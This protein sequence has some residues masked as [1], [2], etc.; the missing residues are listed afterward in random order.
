MGWDGRNRRKIYQTYI[1]R[2]DM[3]VC[4]V[5]YSADEELVHYLNTSAEFRGHAISWI[6]ISK[7]CNFIPND[8]VQ[9]T[10]AYIVDMRQ[11]T[12]QHAKLLNQFRHQKLLENV[13]CIINSQDSR[14]VLAA[15][16]LGVRRFST[17]NISRIIAAIYP[18]YGDAVIL[19][20]CAA[21]QLAMIH[22]EETKLPLGGGG[23]RTSALTSREQQIF[24]CLSHG[25]HAKIIAHNLHISIETL[26]TH[27]KNILAKLNCRTMIQAIA[28]SREV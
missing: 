18:V 13:L 14:Y 22:R 6:D 11:P 25:Q 7:K 27:R 15:L 26:R 3:P 24:D 1:P 12:R 20:L 23:A 5:L 2:T 21:T 17:A 8:Q 28:Q 4:V 16:K 10:N 19:P 9:Q